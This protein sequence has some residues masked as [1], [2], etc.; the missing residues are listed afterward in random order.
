MTL[1]VSFHLL[2]LPA[3]AK[4][5]VTILCLQEFLVSISKWNTLYISPSQR[6]IRRKVR[7]FERHNILVSLGIQFQF[8]ITDFK[9]SSLPPRSGDN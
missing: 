6:E 7:L 2:M 1:F 9:F 8:S 3:L 5:A 4:K